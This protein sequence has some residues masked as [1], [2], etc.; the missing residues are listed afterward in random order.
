MCDSDQGNWVWS[1]RDRRTREKVSNA[2]GYVYYF[3]EEEEARALAER[4]G[5]RDLELVRVREPGA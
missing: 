4:L 2:D 5:D 1:V 3:A